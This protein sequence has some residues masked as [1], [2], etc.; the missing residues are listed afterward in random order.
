MLQEVAD[1][2]IYGRYKYTCYGL[3]N[4]TKYEDLNIEK[5]LAGIYDF[6]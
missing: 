5:H 2:S 6:K 4:V 3:G 1:V